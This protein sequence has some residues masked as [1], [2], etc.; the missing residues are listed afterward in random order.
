VGRLDGIVA[1][2]LILGVALE[3]LNLVGLGGF[4]VSTLNRTPPDGGFVAA[5]AGGLTAGVGANLAA[6]AGL[7]AEVFG[8]EGAFGTLPTIAIF[9]SSS[10]NAER[11]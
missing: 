6:G 5:K 1:T 4:R 2:D 7:A 10:K 9:S 8:A 11:V 3:G